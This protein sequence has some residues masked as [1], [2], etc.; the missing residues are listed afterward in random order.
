MVRSGPS[1]RTMPSCRRSSFSSRQRRC[2]SEASTD[3]SAPILRE[4]LLRR[5]PVLR[6]RRDAGADLAAQAG[7]AHHEEL[8]EVVRRDR[9]EAELLEERMVAVR[10]LLEDAAVELEPGQ[11]AVDEALRELPQ[12]RRRRAR[13]R[14][15]PSGSGASLMIST[16]SSS[17]QTSRTALSSRIHPSRRFA[18]PVSRRLRDVLRISGFTRLSSASCCAPRTTG[19]DRR[20]RRAGR[21]SG[22]RGRGPRRPPRPRGRERS[23]LSAM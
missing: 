1:T 18:D 12:A 8:V 4:L 19:R 9:Q 20:A 21:G 22:P 6:R 2:W 23:I 13:C 10:R 7:D 3:T 17:S 16:W 15:A 5:Q 11:L 14:A